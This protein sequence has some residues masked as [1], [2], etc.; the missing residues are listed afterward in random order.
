[1]ADAAGAEFRFR[2]VLP[3]A[4]GDIRKITVTTAAGTVSVE[5]DDAGRYVSA[6]GRKIDQAAAGGLFDALGGL[7]VE[8]FIAAAGGA[9]SGGSG[10]AGGSGGGGPQFHLVTREGKTYDLQL[11]SADPDAATARLAHVGDRWFRLTRATIDKL[12]A[13]LMAKDEP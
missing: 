8:R 12:R 3:V 7:R 1:L 5:R 9:G 4:S 2:T 6:D 11:A 10:G 13:D